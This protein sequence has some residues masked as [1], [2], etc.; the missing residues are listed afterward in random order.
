MGAKEDPRATIS[1]LLSLAGAGLGH[2]GTEEPS[3][4]DITGVHAGMA[5]P[6]KCMATP[7]Q[8]PP[9]CLLGALE[10]EAG[11]VNGPI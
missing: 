1:A 11:I 10:I 3:F 5:L 8:S 2:A 9:L 7:A 4:A 6:V